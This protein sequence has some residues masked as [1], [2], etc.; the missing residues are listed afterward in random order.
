MMRAA[1]LVPE[2]AK[3]APEQPKVAATGQSKKPDGRSAPKHVA[4]RAAAK[5]K[6]KEGPPQLP[7]DNDDPDY[8]P[9]AGI[10]DDIRKL[11]DWSLRDLVLRFG[12][13]VRFKDWLD[14]L[15]KIEVVHEKRLKN[16]QVEGELVSR[17]VI[18][19]GVIDHINVA[20]QRMLTDGAKSIAT[21]AMTLVHSGDDVQAVQ[22]MVADQLGSFIRPAKSKMTRT[23]KGLG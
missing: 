3:E 4:G 9:L 6:I 7:H 13:D 20:H 5:Q 12:T 23:L 21:R 8:D 19:N 22:D 16:A 2:K 10:P 17:A 11:A 1:G 14:S 15:Q 18:K